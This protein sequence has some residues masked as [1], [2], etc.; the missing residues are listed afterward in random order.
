MVTNVLGER[1]ATEAF[2]PERFAELLESGKVAGRRNR[3][4]IDDWVNQSEW[5][6]WAAPGGGYTS[7]VK[8]HGQLSSWDICSELLE[9]PYHTYL[10]PGSCYHDR[11]DDHIR[12]GFGGRSAHRVPEALERID[13]YCREKLGVREQAERI[14]A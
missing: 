6:S 14:S 5:F 13:Q 8:F 10:V 7:F 1:L 3:Q 2:A 9:P 11:F 4:I 12:F